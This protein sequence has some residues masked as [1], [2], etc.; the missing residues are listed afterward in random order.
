MDDFSEQL[1]PLS[2]LAR[3]IP[4]RRGRKGIDP[5]TC[6]RWAMR[7]CK[8]VRLESVMCGGIR[9]TSRE[10]LARF[11]KRLTDATN[12]EAKLPVSTSKQRQRAI[13]KAKRELDAAGI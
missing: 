11:F 7:G 4:N 8:G 10:A 2:F 3:E 13:D 6:W 5:A 1:L 9:M 12:G